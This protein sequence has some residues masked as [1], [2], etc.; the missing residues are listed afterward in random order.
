[1][2]TDDALD[3]GRESFGR[4]AWAAAFAW[5]SE[6]DRHSSLEPE[7]L[8]QLATAASLIGRDAD[9][10]A[11]RERA[12]H[13]FLSRG[14]AHRAARCACWLALDFLLRGD[15]A[16][17]GGWL[18]RA[19]RLLDDGGHDCVEQG[20]L[21]ELQN[22][23]EPDAATA[24]A[25]SSRAVEIGTRFHDPD[26]TALARLGQGQALIL[27]GQ[28]ARGVARLDEVMV[29]VTAGELTPIVAGI[30]YCAVIETCH[31]IFDPRRAREWTVALTHWCAAQPEL[32]L[33]RGQCLVH[34]AEIMQ[35]H[36]AWP[37]AAEA[38]Q[39]AYERFARQ[40]EHPATGTACYQQ[41][42][43]YRLRG[44]FAKAEE[45]YRRASRWGREPQPGLALLRLMQGRIEGAAAGIRRALKETGDRSARTRMLPAYVEIMLAAAEVPDARVAAD[46]LAEISRAVDAA[47]PRALAAHAQGAVLLAEGNVGV[48]LAT[49]RR[50]WLAWHGL[51]APYEAARVRVLLG[52][53]CRDVADEDGAIMELDAARSAFQQLGATPDIASVEALSRKSAVRIAGGLTAR[54]VQV[55]RLVA[56]GKSNRAIAAELLLS[57]HT[58][59]RHLQNIFTKLDVASRTAATAFAFEHHI[60]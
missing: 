53:A 1:M 49:L 11:H 59:A 42:E 3:L 56:T 30:V 7:D 19:R 33:Y 4:M 13:E 21:L 31:A 18:A 27:L 23:D 50:A 6:A 38:A 52:L 20:Y 43:L 60:I 54:E 28:T 25:N 24:H 35:F 40:S 15:V 14:Q 8:E 10:A 34:R 5:L 39:Q 26:L 46:E 44:E 48:A 51:D 41:G 45:A 16:R 55:L 57:E 32:V 36:G 12:H 22:F 17:A 9:S 58:V 2:T 29:S 37:D 47:L